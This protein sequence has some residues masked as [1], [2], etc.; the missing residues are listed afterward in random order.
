MVKQKKTTAIAFYHDMDNALPVDLSLFLRIAR[1][2]LIK[3]VTD[4]LKISGRDV[5]GAICIARF[6]S[7]RFDQTDEPGS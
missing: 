7:A 6:V 2:H 3:L 4:A 5:F 1:Q